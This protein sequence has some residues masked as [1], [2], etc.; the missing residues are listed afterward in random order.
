MKLLKRIRALR[1]KL[2]DNAS[3]LK[4]ARAKRELYQAEVAKLRDELVK[5]NP[6]NQRATNHK[7]GIDDAKLKYWTEKERKAYLRRHHLKVAIA[8]T[9]KRIARQGP[10]VVKVNGKLAVRGGSAEE[11]IVAVFTHA[12]KHWSNYYSEVGTYD[13]DHALNNHDHD[14]K[15]RDCSWD[16]NEARRA[17]GL[18]CQNTEP[19]YTESLLQQGKSVSRHYAE[20]HAGVAVIYGGAGHTFHVGTSTGHGA[21]TWEHGKPELD[22]GT[23]DEY[24]PTD[25]RSFD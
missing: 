3:G 24:S 13:E 25:Y 22:T 1:S 7:L 9:L 12:V 14:G 4:R 8:R 20:T 2:A 5:E 11:R 16:Y 19:R 21:F 10:K 17:A 6:L 23:F 18:P 15:R